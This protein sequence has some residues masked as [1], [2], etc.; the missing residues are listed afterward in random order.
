M[1]ELSIEEKAKAYDEALENAKLI[2]DMTSDKSAIYTIFPEL[3]ESEDEKI[4]KELIKGISKT[5]PNTPFLDTNVT[6]EEAIAWLEKQ[7]QVN[8]SLIS[9]HENETC[10]ENGN[11][12][13]GEDEKIIKALKE[14][15]K[16]HQL[17]I[18]PTFGGI[19]CIEIV[20]WLE[21]QGEQKLP[22]LTISPPQNDSGLRKQKPSEWSK[23]EKIREW[24]MKYFNKANFNGMLEY[25]NGIKSEDIQDWLERCTPVP[26]RP[27]FINGEIVSVIEEQKPADKVEPKFKV[28]DWITNSIE[29]VQITGYDIDYGYQVDYKGKLQH[30]D[31][32]IIEKE[33][34]LWTIQDAKDGDVLVDRYGNIGIFEKTFG[35]DWDSYCYLGCNGDFM[36]NKVGGSHDLVDT[37][38]ATKEQRTELFLKMHEAGY[39]WDAAK[40]ELKK[41]EQN[42]AWSKESKIAFT[43]ICENCCGRTVELVK[44]IMQPKQKWRQENID[45]LTDFENAMMHIGGSFFGENAGLDPNDTNIIKEQANI[46]LGLV[47]SKEWS[48][49]DED[50]IDQ[51]ILALEDLYDDDC[52]LCR[53]DGYKLPYDKAAKRLKSLR[54][55]NTWKPS[56]AQMASITCAVRKMK[57]S[58]CYDS[59]LVSL[60]NDLKKL[61]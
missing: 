23:D 6:R 55:Q 10:K 51:A 1:K 13:T 45:D 53:Y 8:E 47:L 27:A 22:I 3:E 34:H 40:L 41:I 52:P 42:P 44:N 59:E 16:Y 14:G 54:P 49:E 30:R 15:F 25:V 11:S 39:E 56:D 19:P 57:E 43:D 35:F 29:T 38:P 36:Y 58:P 2:L 28:G 61:K 50:A 32:D 26:V 37:Y 31:T 12:L 7:G 21:K 48:E 17:F 60:F 9:Q 5:R 4:R 24:L 20:N 18:N 46:L 33:Y